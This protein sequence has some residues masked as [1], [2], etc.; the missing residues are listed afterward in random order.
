MKFIL[1]C[2]IG[3]A[4]FVLLQLFR[5]EAANKLSMR[6]ALA[7]QFLWLIR[8]VLI[9]LKIDPPE[10]PGPFL[11]IYDQTLF[12][13]DGPLVWV[14]TRSLLKCEAWSPRIWLHFLPFFLLTLYS[15]QLAV[16]YPAMVTETYQQALVSIK[17]GESFYSLSDVMYVVAVLGISLGYLIRTVKLAKAYN[18]RLLDNFSTVDHLSAHWIITF[19]RMWIVLFL[20]PVFLYF[21]NYIWPVANVELLAGAL[22][23]P[24]VILSLIFSSSLLKQAYK[25]AAS[26]QKTKVPA[27]PENEPLKREQLKSLKNLLEENK[28]YL[29]DELNLS[30]LADYMNLKPADITD[31]IKLSEYDNF[32]DLINSYRIDEVKRE[33]TNSDEQIIQLAYQN[34]FRSKS[35]FNK[36]FKEKTGMTPKEYRLSIK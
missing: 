13:L 14:Y 4:L 34:G 24:L 3:I 7:I 17:N 15:T 32:Y 19:Q 18:L 20:F 16:F 29:D 30:Q 36:I 35:T 23:I 22:L 8:F 33:L 31:L 2:T 9:Y 21:I 28:Y 10:P 1:A 6:V 12:L 11:I 5:K 25:P 26:F 27:A